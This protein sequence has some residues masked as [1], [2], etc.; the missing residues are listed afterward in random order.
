[1]DY[2]QISS[3]AGKGI[4]E[5]GDIQVRGAFTPDAHKSFNWFAYTW[6]LGT[7]AAFLSIPPIH[8]ADEIFLTKKPS[9]K[10]NNLPQLLICLDRAVSGEK[11]N[12]WSF[13]KWKIKVPT[14]DQLSISARRGE[15]ISELQQ[16]PDERTTGEKVYRLSG[17]KLLPERLKT[18]RR[19]FIA[20]MWNAPAVY[21]L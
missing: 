1:M 3:Q 14:P 15:Q 18:W 7:D 21:W 20:R 13:A 12:Y 11:C 10:T 2:W 17:S 6:I 4:L 8:A 9:N 5:L 19:Y 16:L